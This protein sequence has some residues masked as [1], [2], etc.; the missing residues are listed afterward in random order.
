[1]MSLTYA[2]M[3]LRLRIAY[4]P[5]NIT[6]ISAKTIIERFLLNNINLQTL[7][8]TISTSNIN[9]HPDKMIQLRAV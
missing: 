8:D 5:R 1:M 7:K 4:L 6:S 9:P 3:I 2:D